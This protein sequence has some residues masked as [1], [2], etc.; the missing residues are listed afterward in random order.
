M[1]DHVQNG[2]LRLLMTGD[3]H[4]GRTSTRLP[5][6]VDA[7]EY[8]ASAAWER[9]VALA[10][11][12]RIDVVCLSGD[13]ADETNRFWEAIGP[14]EKGIDRLSEAG[15]RTV[16]VAGNHD[17][18]VLGRLAGQFD[19]ER[20]RL[21]GRGGTWE[22]ILI[23]MPGKPRLL[24]DGW[25]FSRRHVETSPLDAYNLDQDPLIPILGMVHGDLGVASSNYAPIDQKR[26]QA[27]PPS[28]WLL[29]HIHAWRLIDGPPWIL[30][31]GSPQAFNPGEEGVHGPWIV[32]VTGSALASPRQHPLS[33]IRYEGLEIDLGGAD[34][35][36]SL[37]RIIVDAVREEAGRIVADRG[38]ALACINLRLRLV[39]ETS[40]SSDVPRAVKEIDDLS[41]TS[42]SAVVGVESVDIQTVPP[43]D[44]EAYARQ[45]SAP[46]AV[47]RLLLE[48]ERDDPEE[49]VRELIEQTRL[50]IEENEGGKHFATLD[51]R[52]VDEAMVREHLRTQGRALL[53]RLAAQDP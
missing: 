20:F 50:A 6:S 37:D 30:Y 36:D 18:E 19:E 13:I 41:L 39:G 25:S 11:E 16:A 48:L 44:L 12:K 46:G 2:A 43:L 45:T 33:S 14:L 4:L 26:L 35:V 49:D 15:I 40:A 28:A 7:R 21:L 51:R 3:L 32:E 24:I 1:S 8:R 17:Y 27:L 10:V 38:E 23:D 29:G 52:A 42:G 47:A 9:I 5:F 34:D 22:R 31:P 53:T